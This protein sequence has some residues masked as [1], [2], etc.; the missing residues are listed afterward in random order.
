MA[1][2][3]RDRAGRVGRLSPECGEAVF[4]DSGPLPTDADNGAVTD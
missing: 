1:H 4:F 3:V 2:S